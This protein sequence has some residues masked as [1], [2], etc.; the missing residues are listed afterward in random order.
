MRGAPSE[1]DLAAD[2]DEQYLQGAFDCALQN[3]RRP[4]ATELLILSLV[5]AHGILDNGGLV[6]FFESDFEGDVTHAQIASMY[7]EIGMGGLATLL[8]SGLA[9]FPGGLPHGD[10]E[11]RRCYLSQPA[12]QE[13]LYSSNARL[14][15][16][17]ARITRHLVAYLK[18][19]T[20]R[21]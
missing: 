20:R 7:E 4:S 8:R 16:E 9:V 11:E 3:S 10:V 2:V 6:Y 5:T 18:V 17:T 14:F 13:E 1:Q 19:R 21:R 15:A 12:V